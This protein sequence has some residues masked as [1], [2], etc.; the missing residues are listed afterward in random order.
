MHDDRHREG[1]GAGGQEAQLAELE[2]VRDV[3]RDDWGW[4]AQQRVNVPRAEVLG[5]GG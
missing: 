1:A 4:T 2:R 5:G 3:V